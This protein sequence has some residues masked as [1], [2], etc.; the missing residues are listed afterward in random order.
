MEK[1]EWW[2]SPALPAV[3]MGTI[4][5]VIGYAV[6][7]RS[8]PEAPPA[9]PAAVAVVAPS[10]VPPPEDLPTATA[11]VRPRRAPGDLSWTT[12]EGYV[13]A[14]TEAQLEQA[15]R[16]VADGDRE[17]FAAYVTRGPD[18][19]LLKEGVQV[20]VVESKGLLA[21]HVKVRLKG[22]TAEFWTVREALAH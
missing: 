6:C 16:L 15:V 9:A 20:F 2:Q 4:A 10:P 17:A 19:F 11:P 13:A 12:R 21:S 18:V 8:K 7:G 22:T 1:V 14:R 3:V 5:L